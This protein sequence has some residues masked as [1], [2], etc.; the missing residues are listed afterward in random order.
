V[1]EESEIP[2]AKPAEN[3]ESIPPA[4]EVVTPVAETLR[5]KTGSRVKS[6]LNLQ[7][8]L[9]GKPGEEK[10]AKENGTK[11]VRR[12][13]NQAEVK[14]VWNAYA[15]A[16]KTQV[17]EYSLLQRDFEIDDHVVKVQLTNPVEVTLL[18]SIKTDLLTFLKEKLQC[19]IILEGVLLQTESKKMIY[20]NKE[21]FDHLA[22]KHPALLEL[23]DRLGLD[24]DY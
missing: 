9:S 11:Y 8:I 19:E 10:Q 5:T 7:N 13:I 6:T 22:E 17:A 16:R 24:T 3:R 2:V 14:E 20:T 1:Q 4:S 18:D 21:K 15:E 12:K 23:K